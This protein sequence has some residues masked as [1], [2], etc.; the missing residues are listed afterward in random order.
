PSSPSCS[1]T[2]RSGAPRRSTW[3][4]ASTAPSGCR[5]TPPAA[6]TCGSTPRA[7]PEPRRPPSLLDEADHVL[8]G[9][10]PQD[11]L[12]RVVA[13]RRLHPGQEDRLGIHALLLARH[14]GRGERS[15][16]DAVA[17]GRIAAREPIAAGVAED[18]AV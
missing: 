6:A 1:S 5:A 7:S 16:L 3:R 17:G 8:R 18:L 2:S 14:H 9:I 15:D 11:L 13:H 10:E 4:W 12:R